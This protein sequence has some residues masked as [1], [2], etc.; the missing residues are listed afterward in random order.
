MSKQAIPHGERNT[1]ADGVRKESGEIVQEYSRLLDL[2][3]ERLRFESLLS[4]LSATFIHLSAEE[5]DGQIERGLQQIVAFLGIDRSSLYQFSPDGS[6]MVVT[7]SFVM[8]GSDPFPRVDVAGMMP[9]YTTQ[10]RRGEMLRYSQLPYGLPP[11]AV[12]E[13]EYCLQTG[14]R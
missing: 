9:W 6:A 2:L 3:N 14:F 7:H 1:G 4:R 5:V 10:I 8:P 11:E 13:R 12:N